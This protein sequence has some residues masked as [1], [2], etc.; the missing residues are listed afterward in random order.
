MTVN[1]SEMNI[2]NL[3]EKCQITDVIASDLTKKK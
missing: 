2:L 1:G 3:N